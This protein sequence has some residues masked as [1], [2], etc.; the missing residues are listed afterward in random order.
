M[1]TS[2]FITSLKKEQPEL[3][4]VIAK[5]AKEGL[6]FV[7]EENDAVTATNRLLI[8]YPGLH[9]I[10]QFITDQW[11]ASEGHQLPATSQWLADLNALAKA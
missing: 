4:A 9:E 7:D 8:T 3:W 1:Q 10:L 2:T 5:A 6:I 11:Y